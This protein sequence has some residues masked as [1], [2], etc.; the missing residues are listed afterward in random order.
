MKNTKIEWADHSW[1][2]YH[3]RCNK[4]SQGCKNCYMMTFAKRL[5]EDPVGTPTVREKAFDELKSYKP[6][7]V[8]FVNSMSDT[9]HEGVPVETIQRLHQ[10][11]TAHPHL[12]FLF[13]TKRIQRLSEIKDQLVFPDNLWTG[14]SVESNEVLWRL[15]YLAWIPGKHFVSAEPLLEK[16]YLSSALQRGHVHWVIVGGESGKNYRP[17]DKQWAQIIRDECL[18]YDVPFLFK[19]GSAFQ[20]GQD[21]MLDGRTWDDTPFASPEPETEPNQLR[22]F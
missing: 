15:D 21:R 17:F 3:W 6:G 22:L 11:A 16:V 4:V 12:I 10:T 5:G 2:P 7:D 9:Y 1:N 14:V 8:L 19:Q 18:T 13:L 20:S